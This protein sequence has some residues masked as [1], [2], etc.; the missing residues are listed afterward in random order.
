MKAVVVLVAAD[1]GQLLQRAA[2]G[3]EQLAQVHHPDFGRRGG[4]VGDRGGLIGGVHDLDAAVVD[5]HHFADE[6]VGF[7]H[8]HHV[9]APAL[10]IDVDADLGSADTDGRH[11]G[12]EGHGVGIGLGHLAGHER[13][14]ALDDGQA[15]GPFLGRRVVDHFIKDDAAVLAHGKRGFV[16]QQD[17]DGAVGAGFDN[18][19]LEDRNA[20]FQFD[21]GAVGADGEDAAGQVLDVADGLAVGAGDH[22]RVV[23]QHDD[24]V[25]GAADQNVVAGIAGQDVV[26]GTAGDVFDI[27]QGVAVA[28]RRRH[29]AKGQGIVFID[30]GFDPADDLVVELDD[31]DAGNGVRLDGRPVRIGLGDGGLVDAVVIERMGNRIVPEVAVDEGGVFARAAEDDVVAGAA[32]QNVVAGIAGQDVVAGTAGDVFDIDQGVAFG[33]AAA[34]AAAAAEAQLGFQIDDHAGDVAGIIGGIDAVTAIQDVG[35]CAADEHVFAGS[36][37]QGVVTR[38]G[39]DEIVAAASKLRRHIAT[40]LGAIGGHEPGRIVLSEETFDG[41]PGAVGACQ[42]QVGSVGFKGCIGKREAIR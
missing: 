6:A 8:Q 13:K 21:P 4:E 36:T 28:V 9:H 18:I 14:D 37:K 15:D 39:V 1:L 22:A 25:A 35:P 11:R 42:K 19:A 34:W 3:F 16:G 23:G 41:D 24:V 27:D 33:V 12:V 10:G 31:L 20:L 29:R 40:D 32:D 2:I 30:H 7:F 26:A 5:D 17:A 38:A